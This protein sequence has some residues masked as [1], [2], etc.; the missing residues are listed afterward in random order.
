ARDEPALARGPEQ[1]A[2]GDVQVIV[3]QLAQQRAGALVVREG[4]LLPVE[5]LVQREPQATELRDEVALREPRVELRGP[6]RPGPERQGR[7]EDGEHD[8]VRP[9]LE[10]LRSGDI[11]QERAGEPDLETTPPVIELS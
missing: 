10:R 6:E 5:V 8:A 11:A 4:A 3:E 7:L 2:V 1:G 9:Q